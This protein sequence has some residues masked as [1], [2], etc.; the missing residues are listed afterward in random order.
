MVS[1]IGP[2][3]GLA[4]ALLLGLSACDA[5][6]QF[7]VASVGS[8]GSFE[9]AG[10]STDDHSLTGTPASSAPLI[11]ASGNAMI[12]R[13]GQLRGGAGL[14]STT[15]GVAAGTV[16][17]VLASTGQTLVGLTNGTSLVLNGAGGAVGDLVS[18]DLGTGRVLQGPAKLVGSTAIGQ[19]TGGAL[20]GSLLAGSGLNAS[21]VT[22]A[23]K[24]TRVTGTS[25]IVATP[26]KVTT[27][28]TKTVGGTL[29]ALCC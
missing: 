25:G 2:R 10:D 6:R 21:P 27:T 29:G 12:G 8:E 28:V 4:A 18:V 17:T 20:N 19:V 11:V 13:A 1:S 14:T 15:G 26:G 23:L 3:L 16:Q 7:R 9:V 5:Q 24:N 22:S